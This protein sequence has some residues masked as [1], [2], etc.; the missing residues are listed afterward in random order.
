MAFTAVHVYDSVKCRQRKN[1][2]VIIKFRGVELGLT[3]AFTITTGTKYME[4]P[5]SLHGEYALRLY[6]FQT[7]Y[8]FSELTK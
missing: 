1:S 5:N 6:N 7:H 8:L 2:V 3:V 4:Y